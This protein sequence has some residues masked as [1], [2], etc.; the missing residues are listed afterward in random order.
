MVEERKDIVKAPKTL[1]LGQQVWENLQILAIALSLALLIRIFLAE[2]RY[3]PSDSMLPNLEVG[4][5]LVVEKVSYH[6]HPPHA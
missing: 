3:I 2:P 4:D 6:F 1:T 5:R